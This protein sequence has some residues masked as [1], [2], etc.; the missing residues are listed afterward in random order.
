[1]RLGGIDWN[2]GAKLATLSDNEEPDFVVPLQFQ[3]GHVDRD[4][5]NVHSDHFTIL[6]LH[7]GKS[8]CIRLWGQCWIST[9]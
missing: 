2:D 9:G 8:H 7:G 3:L 5:P 4:V 6:G 1:M